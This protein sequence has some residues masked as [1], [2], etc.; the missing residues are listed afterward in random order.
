MSDE[1]TRLDEIAARAEG[2]ILPDGPTSL[3]GAMI[4]A[5]LGACVPFALLRPDVAQ[6]AVPAQA[7]QDAQERPG[8]VSADSGACGGGCEAAGALDALDGGTNENGGN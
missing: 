6:G 3:E 2:G 5:N 7:A 1:T 4:R 8:S